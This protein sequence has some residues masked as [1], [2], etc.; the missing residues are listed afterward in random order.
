MPLKMARPFGRR[1]IASAAVI[2]VS[3]YSCVAAREANINGASTGAA[4]ATTRQASREAGRR[5]MVQPAAKGSSAAGH[6]TAKRCWLH[7]FEN[8]VVEYRWV[9]RIMCCWQRC[10]G[11]TCTPDAGVPNEVIDGQLADH[12]TQHI[13]EVA[14][15]VGRPELRNQHNT[16]ARARTHMHAHMCA[17]HDIRVRAKHAWWSSCVIK[18][19]LL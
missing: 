11:P 17:W 10:L 2:T 12:I 7:H 1:T 15:P 9:C 5:W 14:G 4:V 16:S 3:A 18:C 19:G 13:T 8:A 6:T